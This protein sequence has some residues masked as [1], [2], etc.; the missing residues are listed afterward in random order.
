MGKSRKKEESLLVSE[1]GKFM[2]RTSI[3]GKE[4]IIQVKAGEFLLDVL[5]REGYHGV[6]KGCD[7]GDCG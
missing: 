1:N 3:N 7:T 5:R 2:I 4:Q 6:K